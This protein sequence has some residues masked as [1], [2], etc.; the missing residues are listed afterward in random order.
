MATIAFDSSD[1]GGA[2]RPPI[3]LH[4]AFP[5]IVALWFAALLGIG[6]MVL[7]VVLLER[8]V[9]VSGLAA[10]VPAAGPPLGSTAR[11]LI[12]L[13]AAIVGALGGL[14]IARR[15]AGAHGGERVSVAGRFASGARRPIDINAEIGGE[16]LVNGRGLPVDNRRAQA[17]A[18]GELADD[19]LYMAP[20]PEGDADDHLLAFEE[21]FVTE[22]PFAFGDAFAG[23][24]PAP[25][26]GDEPETSEQGWDD[27]MTANQEFQSPAPQSAPE[28]REPGTVRD[29]AHAEPLPFSPPSLARRAPRIEMPAATEPGPAEPQPLRSDRSS[30]SVDDLGLL[31]LAQRLNRSLERRRE[32]LARTPTSP[33]PLPEAAVDFDPAP[34]EDAA[35]AMAAYFGKPAAVAPA[36]E[37]RVAH[38]DPTDTDAAVRAALATLQRMSGA[39]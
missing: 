21:D 29:K 27:P 15:V 31:Q 6:S 24:P 23:P 1:E 11:I 7:P 4:P 14:A 2:P 10:L 34:A 28:R 38:A 8:M 26:L 13:G 18:D 32:W 9:D 3:S 33:V 35:Q 17:I 30:A 37:E 36:V 22:D 25:Q 16:A 39:A 19:D 5:A 20:L 12:A